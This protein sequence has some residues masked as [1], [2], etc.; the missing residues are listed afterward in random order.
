MTSGL[1]QHTLLILRSKRLLNWLSSVWL[2]TVLYLRIVFIVKFLVLLNGA[3][4]YFS[5]MKYL[6]VTLKL[7]SK[8]HVI[9]IH[10]LLCSE[11]FE[12]NFKKSLSEKFSIG[13]KEAFFLLH[14]SLRKYLR[15]LVFAKIKILKLFSLLKC[16]IYAFIFSFDRV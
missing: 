15:N 4:S 12:I 6:L 7:H 16:H 10:F 5:Q 9:R 8:A 14:C 3:R 2:Q 13:K 1:L 11:Q